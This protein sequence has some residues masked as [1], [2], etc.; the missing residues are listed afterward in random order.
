MDLQKAFTQEHLL[1]LLEGLMV[2]LE[3]AAMAIIASFVIGLALGIIRFSNVPILSFLV[4]AYIETIR[5]LPLLLIIFVGYFGLKELGIDLPLTTSVIMSMTVF[6]SALVAEIVR[7]G[8]LS[9]NRGLVEASRAQGFSYLQTLWY[10]VLPLGL[11][12]TIPPMVSQFVALL[13]D[14]SLAVAISLPELT[15]HAQI[16]YNKEFNTTIPI[17]VLVALIYFTINYLLSLT[18][19]YLERHLVG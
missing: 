14:T 13:K 16:I 7:S 17:L 18:S 19:R 11:K 10:L 9:I 4:T 1:F 12:R 15:H 3:V 6:T 2:T 5:N 8:F